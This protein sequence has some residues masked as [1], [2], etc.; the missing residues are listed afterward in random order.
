MLPCLPISN[1]ILLAYLKCCPA[2]LSQ[3][4]P[5]L[6]ICHPLLQN[7]LSTWLD[8]QTVTLSCV[9]SHTV[10]WLVNVCS[11]L[12]SFPHIVT[13]VND[14]EL[15]LCVYV[16]V[17]MCSS[18]TRF[19]NKYSVYLTTHSSFSLQ[20]S[21]PTRRNL[22]RSW[23]TRRRKNWPCLNRSSGTVSELRVC[24]FVCVFGTCSS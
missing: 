24:V 7:T 2:C 13:R 4:L 3:M 8:L 21:M 17:H 11:F 18:V 23:N 20:G 1:V 10:A 5:C 19:H 22:M 16:C 14:R 9:S 15:L 12:F 6:P